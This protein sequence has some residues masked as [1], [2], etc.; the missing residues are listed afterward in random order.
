MKRVHFY[1]EEAEEEW[2]PFEGTPALYLER[3]ENFVLPDNVYV[4]L[5]HLT[6]L[7][8]LLDA[9]SAPLLA[10]FEDEWLEPEPPLCDLGALFARINSWHAQVSAR[11]W[12][13]S[14]MERTCRF[15]S[16]GACVRVF[17]LCAHQN[18][19]RR[20]MFT[21]QC[22]RDFLYTVEA[23]ATHNIIVDSGPIWRYSVDDVWTTT[24]LAITSLDA[25][26]Y[27]P[28]MKLY[29]HALFYRYANLL[30]CPQ[31]EEDRVF[32]N[33]MFICV[34]GAEE[35]SLPV[36]PGTAL[37]ERFVLEGELLFGAQLQRLNLSHKLQSH[38][39]PLPR[40]PQGVVD[41]W[42]KGVTSV[43]DDG[44]LRS[45]AIE[46]FRN[47]V[48]DLHLF[49][50]ERERFARNFPT[51]NSSARDVLTTFR[52][53]HLIAV[54]KLE[55]LPLRALLDG[56]H[57]AEAALLTRICTGLWAQ[58]N[59]VENSTPCT[60]D[61]VIYLDDLCDHVASLHAILFN[62]HHDERP[63]LLRLMRLYYVVGYAPGTERRVFSV[64]Q[65]TTLAE[66]YALW[67]AILLTQGCI[68]ENMI[69]APLLNSV[70]HLARE[71]T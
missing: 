31:E 41:A 61:E 9:V 71:L 69:L 24:R 35:L 26:A 10:P 45:L 1:D 16:W 6:A 7:T 47:N 65:S 5:R 13:T 59:L 51:Q 62:T 12:A 37:N 49:H 70:R 56:E 53:Q 58:Y 28:E 66:A 60:I 57:D 15:L 30:C 29:V 27:S 21:R 34:P 4:L 23:G 43:V 33:P 19:A 36:S 18:E 42:V 52:P 40:M 54:T 64:W 63:V 55:L 3:A 48:A 39:Q 14:V 67:L 44:R 32:D 25:H 11:R 68:T 22:A 20:E 46:A 17:Y 8:A 2:L 50:G 38:A